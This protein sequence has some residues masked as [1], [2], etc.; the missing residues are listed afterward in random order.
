[1]DIPAGASPQAFLHGVLCWL[2]VFALVYGF[3]DAVTLE[4][5]AG[6]SVSRVF[7]PCLDLKKTRVENP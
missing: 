4:P 2:A 5:L 3:L 1:M 6:C 7:K